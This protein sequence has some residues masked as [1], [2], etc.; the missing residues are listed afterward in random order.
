MVLAPGQKRPLEQS[1]DRSGDGFGAAF[2]WFKG[3]QLPIHA[4]NVDVKDSSQIELQGVFQNQWAPT[5]LHVIEMIH[6]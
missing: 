2:P 1:F 6:F 3:Y 4:N 5:F